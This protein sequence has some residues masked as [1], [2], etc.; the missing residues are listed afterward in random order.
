MEPLPGTTVDEIIAHFNQ[1]EDP[2]SP[3][4]RQ[5]PLVSVVVIALMAV[6]AGAGGP[7]AIARWAETKKDFLLKVLPLPAGIPRKDVFRRV[8]MLMQPAA[9]QACFFNWLQ[10]LRAK[11]AAAT[12]V[13]QPVLAVDGKTA[14]RSHDRAHGLGA[15]HAVSIWASEY[16]LSLGQV[17]CAEKSNDSSF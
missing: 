10:A 15:L 12:G 9:F 11:A 16:G 13:D 17:A 3:I 2:R 7:T 5:H 4:N 14:R 6:L 8:L 1:L